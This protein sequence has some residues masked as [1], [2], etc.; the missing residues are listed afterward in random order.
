MTI[1]PLWIATDR[2]FLPNKGGLA[3]QSSPLMADLFM[4]DS[5]HAKMQKQWD[6]DHKKPQS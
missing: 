2:R 5:L 6:K 1:W 4:L 3:S